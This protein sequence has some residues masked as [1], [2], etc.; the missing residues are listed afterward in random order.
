MKK[1]PQLSSTDLLPSFAHISKTSSASQHDILH[2]LHSTSSDDDQHS[3]RYVSLRRKRFTRRQRSLLTKGLRETRTSKSTSALNKL[4]RSESTTSNSSD[5]DNLN[6]RKKQPGKTAQFKT[7]KSFSR[8]CANSCLISQSITEICPNSIKKTGGILAPSE[9]TDTFQKFKGPAARKAHRRTL[10]SKLTSRD[11]KNNSQA[12]LNL[13]TNNAL[14][15][16]D[17]LVRR[18]LSVRELDGT[19]IDFSNQ[20]SVTRWTSQILAELDSLPSSRFDLTSSQVTPDVVTIISA[21][22]SDVTGAIRV[23]D[24][25]NS[26]AVVRAEP[27]LNTSTVFCNA[28]INSASKSL[29]H[30]QSAHAVVMNTKENSQ[31]LHESNFDSSK[32]INNSD[33]N[34]ENDVILKSKNNTSSESFRLWRFLLRKKHTPLKK[35]QKLQGNMAENSKKQ[36]LT[37]NNNE[38]KE[39]SIILIDG[40]YSEGKCDVKNSTTPLYEANLFP[41]NTNSDSHNRTKLY[42]NGTNNSAECVENNN[43][44]LDQEGEEMEDHISDNSSFTLEKVNVDKNASLQTLRESDGYAES[45]PLTMWNKQIRLLTK[46]DSTEISGNEAHMTSICGK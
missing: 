5:S 15:H 34:P 14:H 29:S 32:W 26:S 42:N 1:Y 10:Q 21:N 25:K 33:L 6:E 39:S 22:D 11:L 41:K 2:L 9:S 30:N 4:H 28:F 18:S 45:S 3:E 31:K 24:Q 13:C 36:K 7:S 38:K 8:N 43:F 17:T 27:C 44:K 37:C 19:M 20:D 23:N 46:I 35:N 40:A 12:G 16:K